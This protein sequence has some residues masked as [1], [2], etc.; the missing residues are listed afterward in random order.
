M[1]RKLYELLA[2]LGFNLGAFVWIISSEFRKHAI[3][4]SLFSYSTMMILVLLFA[5]KNNEL[6]FMWNGDF[7]DKVIMW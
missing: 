7:Y 6:K 5:K 3:P 4:F 1:N 2:I